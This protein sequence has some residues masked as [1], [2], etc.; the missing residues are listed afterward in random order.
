MRNIDNKPKDNT[1]RLYGFHQHGTAADPLAPAAGV[2]DILAAHVGEVNE[3]LIFI[4]QTVA[5]TTINLSNAAKAKLVAGDKV[6]LVI[7]TDAT[8][9]TVTWGTNIKSAA[10]TKAIAANGKLCVVGIFDGTDLVI[11]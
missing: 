3:N 9:R 10:A 5:A 1:A 4:G 6:I 7:P 11:Q 8:G 2:V